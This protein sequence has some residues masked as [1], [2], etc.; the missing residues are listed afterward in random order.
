M[1]FFGS[2]F[3]IFGVSAGLEL[4]A[5]SLRA[6]GVEARLARAFTVFLGAFRFS[7]IADLLS[8]LAQEERV[9]S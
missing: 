7:S 3:Q 1:C 5:V 4:L 8:S 9:T 6:V 2:L